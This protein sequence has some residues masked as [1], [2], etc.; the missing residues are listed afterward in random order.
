LKFGEKIRSVF[1]NVVAF[2]QVTPSL[3]RQ[4]SAVKPYVCILYTCVQAHYQ[5]GWI[6]S[7]GEPHH[8]SI[9]RQSIER[10][11]GLNTIDQ[12]RYFAEN[13]AREEAAAPR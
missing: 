3:P 12:S 9:I 2:N 13:A 11:D 4:L 6:L 8:K 1:S 5:R 10:L 7:V